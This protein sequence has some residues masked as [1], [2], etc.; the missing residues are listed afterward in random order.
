MRKGGRGSFP[1][2]KGRE[3]SKAG[4][5]HQLS[6]N[7]GNLGVAPDIFK[8][9]LDK[10]GVWPV[11]DPILK[12]LKQAVGD[13]CSAR[14]NS[15]NLGYQTKQ[16]ERKGCF[17][18]R[19]EIGQST[20]GGRI[21]ESIFN[22]VVAMW[23]FN[24][25]GPKSGIVY[26][27]FA[28]G[29]T[30]AIVAVKK[31][32]KYTGIEC[33]IEEVEAINIRLKNNNVIAKI[34]HG[35]SQT[36]KINSESADFLITCPP[37]YNMETYEGGIADLSCAETYDDFLKGMK[38]VIAKT[39]QILKPGSIACWVIGLHRDKRGELLHIPNDISRIHKEC[40]FFHK[41]EVIL[42]WNKNTTGALRRVGNFEKGNHLLIRN[43]EY[44]EVFKKPIA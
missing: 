37:Y 33:R 12:G 9:A 20:C 31:G 24:L 13:G 28:G 22:P 5:R 4:W 7:D 6:T 15:G 1:S 11:T 30:R 10:Y 34:I 40:G 27:P 39:F 25:F 19:K 21:S 43:H 23:I 3:R 41:E 16:S 32:L 44:L 18:N 2:E 42:N 36:I 38:K 35:D 26:D 17:D 14:L 8:T 29:G